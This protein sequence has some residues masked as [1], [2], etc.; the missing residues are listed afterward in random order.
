MLRIISKRVSPMI[1]FPCVENAQAF[2]RRPE[3]RGSSSL[4]RVPT[5]SIIDD[6]ESLREGTKSLVRSLGY[7]ATTFSSA[8]EYL[9]SDSIWHSSCVITDLHMPGMTG[10]ELQERLIADGIDTPIILMT[11]YPDDKVRSRALN[12]GAVGFLRKPFDDEMLI[13]CLTKALGSK[14]G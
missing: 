5:I 12:A 14:A 7:A 10:A 11:A 13:E 3:N 2:A 6:D 1:G 9:R 4:R 8:K